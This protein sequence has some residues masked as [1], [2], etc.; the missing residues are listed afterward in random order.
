MVTEHNQVSNNGEPDSSSALLP[1]TEPA[2]NFPICERYFALIHSFR[3]ELIFY[4]SLEPTPSPHKPGAAD[5]DSYTVKKISRLCDD[6]HLL[7]ARLRLR[8][9]P[10]ARLE[11][12]IKFLNTHARP[13]S[14]LTSTSTLFP[15]VEVLLN[16]FR[17]LCQ[18]DKPQVL[19]ITINDSRNCEI[20]VLSPGR[21]DPGAR[22]Y[23]DKYLE[24]W[25]QD[26][27][28]SQAS[29]KFV[30]ALEGYW[31]IANL[32]SYIKYH[33]GTEQ[34]FWK[35]TEL[36]ATAKIARENGNL[37]SLRNVW[38]RVATIWFSY[39]DEQEVFQSKITQSILTSSVV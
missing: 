12:A 7:V 25:S 4:F 34:K 24:L 39:L 1:Q 15:A 27:S 33:R 10:I 21:M 26:L 16:P 23:Y 9:Q 36:L 35:L 14:V 11:I 38:D 19:S 37:R 8:Q 17:R 2:W 3:V 6:L 31:R 18:V 22:S 30:H 32:V 29:F 5:L 28:N 13:S 20:N